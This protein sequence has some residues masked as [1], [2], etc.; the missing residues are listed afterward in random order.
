MSNGMDYVALLLRLM[1]MMMIWAISRPTDFCVPCP[2][3]VKTHYI[4]Q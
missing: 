2:Q 1:M 4:A 3:N